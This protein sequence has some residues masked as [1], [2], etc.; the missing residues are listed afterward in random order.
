MNQF[1]FVV[2]QLAEHL[3]VVWTQALL[4]CAGLCLQGSMTSTALGS[5]GP[6]SDPKRAKSPWNP[7]DT[8]IQLPPFP[9]PSFLH[10]QDSRIPC[11]EGMHRFFCGYIPCRMWKYKLGNQPGLG[12]LQL[13]AYEAFY[14]DQRSRAWKSRELSIKIRH[15]LVPDL[16]PLKGSGNVTVVTIFCKFLK[17]PLGSNSTTVL[18][19]KADFFSNR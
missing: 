15:K 8:T 5:P 4:G 3:G 14:R 7:R 18:S 12:Y 1:I 16:Y 11:L 2:I 19:K 13:V 10:T 17:C 6:Y 9:G